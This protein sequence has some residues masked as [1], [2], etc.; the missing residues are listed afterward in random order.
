LL[1][2]TIP[3]NFCLSAADNNPDEDVVASG[4]E[5]STLPVYPNVEFSAFIFTAPFPTKFNA[6]GSSALSIFCP[7]I[8]IGRYFVVCQV[9]SS[10]RNLSA[11]S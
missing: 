10:L 2:K 9:P 1:G 5:I 8:S 3:S 6:V 7:E 11:F 4:T